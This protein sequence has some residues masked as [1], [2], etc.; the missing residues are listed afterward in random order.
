MTDPPEPL[1]FDQLKL[2]VGEEAG[3][4]ARALPAPRPDRELRDARRIAFSYVGR[5]AAELLRSTFDGER[6]RTARAIYDALAELASDARS[7]EFRASRRRVGERAGVSKRTIDAYA[8]ELERVGLLHVVRSDHTANVWRLLEVDG[9]ARGAA[10]CAPTD[11]R[12]AAGA[13]LRAP[14]GR[15]PLRPQRQRRRTSKKGTS[16]PSKIGRQQQL[17]SRRLTSHASTWRGAYDL[18]RLQPMR[19][20]VRAGDARRHAG[21]VP[22]DH[23][24]GAAVGAGLVDRFEVEEARRRELDAA[25]ERKQRARTN[26]AASGI[27]KLLRGLTWDTVNGKP[28]EL[29]AAARNW[30]TGDV[31]GLVMCSPVGVGKT[32]LA[33][34]AAWARL[35]RGL[36]VRWFYVPALFAQLKLGFGDPR[37]DAAVDALIGCSALVLDDIDKVRPSDY[38][39]EQLC[40]AIDTRVT[41]GKPLLI[42]TNLELPELA[43]RFPNGEAIV[44]RL[45]GYCEA[46]TLTGRDR[47]LDERRAA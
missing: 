10:R 38:A 34:V 4:S 33:A 17:R 23:R 22:Q 47:R 40:C 26:A 29:V 31:Q 24:G 11:A 46:F 25:R 20:S 27:P 36:P 3:S 39:A 19:R 5:G 18:G 15:S 41:A 12:G 44:S 2:G 32:Y 16:S 9:D 13:P 35:E 6:L 42:T 7:S 21:H 1:L 30:A 28:P 8:R 45:V 14:E 37:H 43:A